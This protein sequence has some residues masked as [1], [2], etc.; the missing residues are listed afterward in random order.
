VRIVAAGLIVLAAPWSASAQ[1]RQKDFDAYVGKSLQILQTPG[2]A[3]A[4]VKNGTVLFARGYGVRKLGE[5]TPVDAHTLFQIGSNTKA[6]TT[7]ALAILADEGKLSWDDPVTRLLPGFQLYDPYVTREFTI[8]DLVTHRSGLG[9]GAGDLLWFHSNYSRAEIAY[10]IRF[11]RP[12]S[13]F[14]SQ[15]AYDNVLY[16]V[17]GEVVGAG[18][19]AGASWDDFVRQR[20]FAPLGMTET[21]TTTAYFISNA[22]A[23]AP[24]RPGATSAAR[25]PRSMR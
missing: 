9:L 1:F 12:V 24:H 4:V 25:K 8:R 23:A 19:G 20:I 17:A 15:Y 5:P 18:A 13:S 11:A 21:G 22:N 7:A 3:V 16:I 2:A 6:F 14:R 10:R